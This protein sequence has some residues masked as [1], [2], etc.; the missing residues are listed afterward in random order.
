M[1]PNDNKNNLLFQNGK[2]RKDENDFENP[3][4]PTQ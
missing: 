2:N 3:V 1:D 4:K